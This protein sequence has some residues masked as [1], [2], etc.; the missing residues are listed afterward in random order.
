MGAKQS[1]TLKF[2]SKKHILSNKSSVVDSKVEF[3]AEKLISDA[4]KK[5]S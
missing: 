1:S 5:A 3:V 2:Y 4:E